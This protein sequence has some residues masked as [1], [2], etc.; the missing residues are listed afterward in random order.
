MHRRRDFL[1]VFGS[2]A[3]TSSITAFA[4]QRDKIYRIGYLS[5][6]TRESVQRTLDAFL[7]KLRD[8]GWV[9]GKNL[10]IEYRWAEGDFARLPAL[11]AELVQRNVD[12]IVAPASSAAV[13]AKKAT[14]R[15][16]I[17]MVFPADPVELGLVASLNQPG[18]NITGTTF[19]AGLGFSGKLLEILKQAIPYAVKVAILGNPAD[20]FHVSQMRELDAAAASLSI[21]LQAF[22]APDSAHLD[23]VFSTMARQQIDALLIA[24]ASSLLPDRNKLAELAVKERL[25]MIGPLREFAEAGGLLSY[26]VNMTDFVE[27]AAVYVDKILKGAQPA[28]LPVEQPTKFELVINLKTAKALGIALPPVLLARADVVIE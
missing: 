11:A 1:I 16:P 20:P 19:T 4:Q 12:L 26:G 25:P 3:A 17:V 27:R 14:S 7:R 21:R 24:T 18:G 13:A 2:L 9:E 10:I 15:I 5:A 8:L 22:D 6:P 28:D 23:K